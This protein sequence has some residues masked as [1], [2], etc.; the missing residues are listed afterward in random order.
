[1]RQER[2][3]VILGMGYLMEYIYP[4]YKHMLGEAAGRCMAAVTADGADLARK[5][6]KFE[7]PVILDDNAGALEQMEPEIILFAPPPA[8]A[9]GLMEQVLAP[10]Y[11]K[12]R[13]RG[14]K[15]PVLYAFPPKPEGRAYLEML[16]SDILVAN[17]LPN[18]V[19]R[20]AGEPLAGEGLTY[21]TFPDEGPWPKEERDYLL[22]FFSP[23]GGCIEVKPAHVMQMLAGTVTVHNISEIILTVSDA[24]ERSGSP[25]DFHRIAGAMRAYHQKKWSYSPA[26]SAPC[27]EDEVEEPL[28][29][30]LRK[31]T[32]H[33]FRG[34]YRFYQDAGMDEDTASR[35]L[36]SLLDLHLHLHQKE[37]RSVIE[38]SGI[39]HAT[40]GGV[41]EKGCLVFARQVE[42]ELARTFEQWPDVNLSDEWCSWLEQQAYSIT[43]QVADHSKHLTGAGEG[44]FAVE[45]H[46][47]MFG[48]LAR[49][50]LEVCG[51]SGREIV[52]AGT[53]HYAH[54]RGHRMR[55]RCQRDG[56]PTDMIH[57]MAYGEWTPEPGT[58][59]I[60]TRQ[61]SP[62]N[63][64]L[65]V[66]CPW[67]TA[68]KKYGLSDYARHY[69]DYADFALV[70]GFDGGLALDMDSWM[71]RG[72]SGCGF[73]W[74]GAD[75]NGESEAEIARVKTLNRKDGVLDWEYHTAHMYYAFC[76][77][78]E[79]LLDP[80][81]RGEVVSGVRAEFEERFGSGALA[82]IDRFASVDF[83]RLER[84]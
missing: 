58:M 39:Q 70:E 26:G 75:L 34:I 60:R 69:C 81:T 53:R 18:M 20:I 17:I 23:L 80:E 16:G 66:K 51:E 47:V 13:E 42:R 10:Y 3:M 31:V 52:K 9:P 36:V 35:I 67:M 63:R 7:F 46:A 57:Y 43:A 21:L 68:W 8:V 72:D 71:A 15:L 40:K 4:C 48:L 54:G 27:R 14:G 41:L 37:D 83:F 5:R 38:A 61:K 84:P 32:Y 30:A 12:V 77:V 76:Q 1:L 74:N 64:T 11:R 45:H 2:N 78:F 24:L 49:A 6:E 19:S 25:V 22:E 65:V 56:N 59:E 44:R 79:K 33:W 28:F 62:V 82:V 29:L 50:V 73:T 55:L